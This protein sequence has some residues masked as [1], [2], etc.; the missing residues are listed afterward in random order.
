MSDY[1]E[2]KTFKRISEDRIALDGIIWTTDSEKWMPIRNNE[3]GHMLHSIKVGD[4]YYY[5]MTIDTRRNK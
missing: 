4:N 1:M 5:P 2:L 3:T